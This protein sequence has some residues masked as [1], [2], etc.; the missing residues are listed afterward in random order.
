MNVVVKA[1]IAG[2]AALVLIQL[3]PY[4][5]NHNNPPTVAE[6]AWSSPEIRLM[7]KKACF[8]CHS[9]ETVWPFYASI[10]PISWLVKYD[11]A[12]GRKKLNFSDWQGGKLEG[13][14]PIAV[15][16]EITKGEMPP[17]QYVIAHP[18]AKLSEADRKT[19]SEGLALTFSK[20]IK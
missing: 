17:F 12:A 11:V 10:A 2:V 8:D 13:E 6:P 9:N 4:G 1:A 19:L 14:D 18:E 7:T 20:S 5:R 3:V 15:T 16:K